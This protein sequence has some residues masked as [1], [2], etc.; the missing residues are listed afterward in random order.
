MK[1]RPIL[2][3]GAMVRAILAGQK[4]Q[5]RRAVK[6][7]HSNPL[8]AW[9]PT[10]FGGPN[11][12]R[13]AD[14]RTIP[15]QGGIWH[16]RTGDSP[17]SPYGQ[18]GDRLWVRETWQHS[19]HPLGPYDSDCLAF[20]RAD[21]LDDPLGPDLEHSADG[22]RRQ[23][24]PSIHMPRSAC[25]LVLEITGVRVERL[26][27]ISE[28]DAK[29]E[30]I[31]PREVRQMWLFGASAEECA[32]TYR[33]AAVEPFHELWEQINGADAWNANPWVWVVEFRRV[34]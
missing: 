16:T 11:G 8:G 25:R 31:T 29:A 2:F 7:P 18:P 9:E 4:T 19:N 13:T 10:T 33:R 28:A 15:L 24:R 30:G 20:Y 26:H 34:A 21:Y 5:T 27:D 22:I 32:A 17:A 12:G 14:G 23:W 3:S 6:L 1:E